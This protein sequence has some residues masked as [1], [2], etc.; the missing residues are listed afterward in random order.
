MNPPLFRVQERR[1][2]AALVEVRQQTGF[3]RR[4]LVRIAPALGDEPGD[5]PARNAAHALHEH[6]QIVSL[7]KAPHD[8]AEFVGW[9]RGQ[10]R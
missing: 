8:L 7:P 5:R 9:Q 1:R 6:K 2:D 4:P 10:R 3:V